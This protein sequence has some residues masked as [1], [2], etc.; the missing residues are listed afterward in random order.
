MDKRERV[1]A[2]LAG[3][4]VD[5][6]PVGFWGHDFLRE[7]T[8]QGL[9]DAMVESVQRYDID[10]LKVNPRATYYAEAWGC[11]YRP[12]G[13]P[14]LGPETEAWV[15]KSADELGS[16]RPLDIGSGPFGEQLEALR[17][18]GHRLAGETP[19]IQ[20]VFSPL[21]VLGRLAN[22]DL[23]A[24][25]EYMRDFAPALHGAL[26][27][28]AETLA[29]YTAA[30]LKA[31]ADGIFF[32]TVDWGTLD[33]CG[34]EQYAEF[35]RP[36]D[37]RVLK[38]ARGGSFNVLHVCRQNNMLV[39]LLDYP[40][41]AFNWAAALPGN[42]SLAE[43]LSKTDKAVM[44]GLNERTTLLKGSPSEVQGEAR[45]ALTETAGRRFLLAPGCSISPQTPEA[46]LRAA[47]GVAREWTAGARSGTSR[48]GKEAS[49]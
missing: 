4:P 49:R 6:V 9:A 43:V 48:G 41:Q 42:P 8:P 28:I 37:M 45:A 32:A 14:A 1:K 12:S 20:T 18:I 10:Y 26:A 15:L 30:C 35:G 7:W 44:G 2:A 25:R 24:V 23:S 17:L 16:I 40:V 3:R 47:V 27:A 11:R 39:D 38:V 13:D 21:S 19:F 22:G 36:Y 34:P 46:N 33:S 31:G 29:R 5:R